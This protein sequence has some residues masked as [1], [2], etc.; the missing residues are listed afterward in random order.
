M[1]DLS[2]LGFVLSGCAIWLVWISYRIYSYFSD[3]KVDE[4]LQMMLD[5][6][7]EDDTVITIGHYDSSSKS[8]I[9]S[10]TSDNN[11][12]ISA[13]TFEKVSKRLNKIKEKYGPTKEITLY[14]HTPGGSLFY[15][16]LI[17]HLLYNW[18]GKKNAHVI[19]YSASGGTLIAL[20][21]DLIYLNDDSVLGPIDPQMS[22]PDKFTCSLIRCEEIFYSMKGLDS[23]NDLTM[24]KMEVHLLE[25]ETRKIMGAYRNFLLRILSQHYEPGL[26]R[27][28]MDFFLSDRSHD[29]PIYREECEEIGLHVVK[30]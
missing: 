2:L 6:E 22:L 25:A 15:S 28:I 19:G 14:L 12:H 9:K 21:C 24:E 4:H 27:Q 11:N 18:K 13:D 26:A 30:V 7:K 20:A 10:L 17:A 5:K 1:F 29:Q 16:Q 8:I 23:R 3:N